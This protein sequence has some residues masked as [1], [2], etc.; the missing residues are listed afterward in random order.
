[1]SLQKFQD[2][3]RVEG[4]KE[5][6]VR[7]YSKCIRGYIAWL[8]DKQPTSDNVLSF[9]ATLVKRELRP[10]TIRL[11]KIAL[12]LYFDKENLKFP[13]VKT[14][15]VRW[16]KPKALSEAEMQS[17]YRATKGNPRARTLL[18]FAYST[19]VRVEELTTRMVS[20][21]NIKNPKKASVF[22][23][24]KTG[25]ETD[26][27]LPLDEIAVRDLKAYFDEL[28]MKLEDGDYIFFGR[29]TKTPMSTNTAREILYAVQKKAKMEKTGWHVIRHSRLTHMAM[30]GVSLSMIQSQARHTDPKMTMRYIQGTTEDLREVSKGMTKKVLE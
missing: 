22:V 17:L 5:G 12:K 26:A 6:S 16:G 29:D 28:P 21:L 4:K 1:M 3:L 30:N 14:P 25:P 10:S 7:T 2:I 15:V 13:K 19:A 18:S 11:Y 23:A 27:W 9:M 8:K 20:D 24:G